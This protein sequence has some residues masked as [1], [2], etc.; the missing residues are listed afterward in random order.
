[1]AACDHVL[2][3][4]LVPTRAPMLPAPTIRHASQE[5]IRAA[6]ATDPGSMRQYD[7]LSSRERQVVALLAA[8]M[9]RPRIATRLG[10][11]VNT[12]STLVR[13]AYQKLDVTSRAQLQFR[14]ARI[15]G[16]HGTDGPGS[17]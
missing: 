9:T 1:M 11:S 8:G 6:Q 10:V 16:R 17:A 5:Q 7:D 4:R 2:A 13:R 3:I 12:V 15:R 14:L